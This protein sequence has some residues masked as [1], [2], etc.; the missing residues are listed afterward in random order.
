M[1]EGILDLRFWILDFCDT[2]A[3]R[4][5]LLQTAIIRAIFKFYGIS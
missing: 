1:N 3:R 4:A 2:L 5:N